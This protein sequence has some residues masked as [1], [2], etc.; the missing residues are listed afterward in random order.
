MA[1]FLLH[2]HGHCG[3]EISSRFMVVKQN[4]ALTDFALTKG[5]DFRELLRIL[6]A[7]NFCKFM[8]F[9]GLW[10]RVWGLWGGALSIYSKSCWTQLI[11]PTRLIHNA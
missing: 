6:R 3:S 8:R 5:R 4:T 10:F 9:K 11:E 7:E 1:C 2:E